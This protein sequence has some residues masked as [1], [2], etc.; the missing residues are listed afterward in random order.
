[1]SIAEFFGLIISLLAI[2]F[3]LYKRIREERYKREHPDEYKKKQRKQEENLKLFLKSL[4]IDVP[5]EEEAKPHRRPPPVKWE[6]TSHVPKAREEYVPRVDKYAP[7]KTAME[8]RELVS[9]LDT[10]YDKNRFDLAPA[11]KYEVHN[12]KK[13]S[14]VEKLISGLHS[15]KEMVL[16]HVVFGSPKGMP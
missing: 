8:S 13:A 12:K 6:K 4:D 5:D 15:R 7:Q 3:L 14:R 1:M 11:P 2:F 9:A 16:L 10:R